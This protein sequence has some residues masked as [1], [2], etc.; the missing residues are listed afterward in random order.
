M[1]NVRSMSSSGTAPA[2]AFADFMRY[3][4]RGRAVVEFQTEMKLPDWQVEPDEEQMYADPGDDYYYVDEQGHLIEP[5]GPDPR[6]VTPAPEDQQL[7]PEPARRPDP[8]APAP[9][10]GRPA[11]QA[12]SDDFLD[13]A[14][15]RDDEGGGP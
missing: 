8:R 9:V 3:A 4:V 5:A 14:T 6:R 15:G 1:L 2:R 10:Q 7:P 12:A 13:K 11:P